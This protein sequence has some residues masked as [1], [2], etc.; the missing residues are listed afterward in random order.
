MNLIQKVKV[1]NPRFGTGNKIFYTISGYDKDGF[2]EKIDKR[3]SD[4]KALYDWLIQR[5]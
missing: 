3:Y 1:E 4:F 5:Y 2:F